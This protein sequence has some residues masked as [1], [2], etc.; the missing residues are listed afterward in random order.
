MTA[1]RRRVRRTKEA[2]HK[3]EPLSPSTPRTPTSEIEMANPAAPSTPSP[4]PASPSRTPLEISLVCYDLVSV[5]ARSLARAPPR[6]TDR[7]AFPCP[8]QLPPSRLSSFLN[9]IGAG[10]YHTALAIELP[11]PIGPGRI[12]KREAGAVKEQEYAFG[13]HDQQG[14][15]GIFSLPV[16]TAAQ[17]MVSPPLAHSH[18]AVAR[19]TL[20]GWWCSN[21]PG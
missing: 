4:N 5:A 11:V 13:G 7:R 14:A 17:R 20:T 21:S 1:S 8:A 6:R 10:V 18:A 15:T 9:L 3:H 2:G 12:A 16:G 19:R